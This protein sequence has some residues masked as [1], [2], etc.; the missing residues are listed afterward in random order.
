MFNFKKNDL[1]LIIACTV[2]ISACNTPVNTIVVMPTLRPSASG[3]PEVVAVPSPVVNKPVTIDEIKP[4]QPVLPDILREG[5]NTIGSKPIQIIPS[6]PSN[7][8]G[9]TGGTSDIKERATFNGKIYDENGIVVEGATVNAKSADPNVSW[10]GET[11]VTTNGAYVFRNAPVGARVEI[12]VTKEGWTTRIRTEVLKSNLQGDPTANVFDFGGTGA[13]AN[14]TLSLQYAIH[15]EPE[16][17][18]VKINGIQVTSPGHNG[19]PGVGNLSKNRLEIE[20]TFSEPVKRDDFENSFQV[21]SEP[22]DNNE[23]VTIDNSYPG[24]SFTWAEDDSAVF[25]RLAGPLQTKESSD[26][27]RYTLGF[28]KA[29]KDKTEKGALEGKFIRFN[30]NVTADF[31]LFSVK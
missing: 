2:T 3:S 9:Q 13:N 8:V 29:F 20:L 4:I 22:L 12:T 10:V 15:D 14:D 17:T 19:S 24:I 23:I 26:T 7:P 27:T 30:S 18:F 11:Q 6:G 21:V 28:S 31:V 1:C 5:P 25:F 16:I